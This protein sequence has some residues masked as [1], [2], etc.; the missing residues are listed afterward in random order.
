MHCNTHPLLELHIIFP[1]MP[2]M[3]DIPNIHINIESP[4]SHALVRFLRPPYTFQI[5]Q[6]PEVK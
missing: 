2:G 5:N 6:L 4:F 1:Q 3:D